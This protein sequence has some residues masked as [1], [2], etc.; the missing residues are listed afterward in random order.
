MPA[1][2]GR[3]SEIKK[4]VA[5]V[6]SKKDN[7]GEPVYFNVQLLSAT[8]AG[9]AMKF[10]RLGTLESVLL[11]GENTLQ[12]I[13]TSCLKHFQEETKVCDIL[14]G[15]RGP[16]AR[17]GYKADLSKIVHC[18]LLQIDDLDEVNKK[19]STSKSKNT[20]RSVEPEGPLKYLKPEKSTQPST[21]MKSIVVP[22]SVHPSIYMK[23]GHLIESNKAIFELTLEK[24]NVEKM[25]WCDP[26]FAKF[27]I[28]KGEFSRGGFQ[29]VFKAKCIKGGLERGYYLLKFPLDDEPW[30]NPSVAGDPNIPRKSVQMHSLAQYFASRMSFEAP[31][32]FGECFKYTTPY[33]TTVNDV[34][35]TLEEYL[36]DGTF[37]KHINNNGDFV[38]GDDKDEV[39]MKAETFMH[40]S[41]V[42]SNEALMVT[43]IQGIRYYLTDP[44]VASKQALDGDKRFFCEGNCSIVAIT[45]FLE[46]H[47][48]KVNKFCKLFGFDKE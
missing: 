39:M 33:F 32:E 14:L 36:G 28:N 44:E 2:K 22:K 26:I 4:R 46:N 13:K 5:A 8:P 16:S 45:N 30:E 1:N 48:C 20:E 10:E 25:E 15:E 38:Q 42:K 3:T 18:R 19:A 24:F 47:E 40:F 37:V 29:K 35:A 11:T 17:E 41:Y 34:A 12:D 31:G 27:V 7:P 23:A 21:I 9:K 6:R 43:D